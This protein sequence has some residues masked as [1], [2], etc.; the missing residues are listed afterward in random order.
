[1]IKKLKKD[2]DVTLFYYNPNIHPAGEYER[3]LDCAKKVGGFLEVPLIEGEYAVDAWLDM[4][5]GFESEPEGG[6]RCVICFADRLAATAKHAKENGFDCFTTTLMISP[7]KD[8]KK[9]NALGENL[10]K[11]HKV[12]WVHSDLKKLCGSKDS[13]K[14]GKTLNLYSQKYC[15]CFYS[16]RPPAEKHADDS[17]LFK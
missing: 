16:V 5:A 17:K 7:G 3:R 4:I 12:K 8:V 10:A 13:A 15:G 1:M 9:I 11:K 6:K 2:Y 14:M